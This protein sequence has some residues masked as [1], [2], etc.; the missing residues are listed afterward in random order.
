MTDPYPPREYW[1][2]VRGDYQRSGEHARH[3]LEGVAVM[4]AYSAVAIQSLAAV[5]FAAQYHVGAGLGMVLVS[6]FTVFVLFPSWA[7]RLDARRSA[8]ADRLPLYVRD[9]L[10]FH[11]AALLRA[12]GPRRER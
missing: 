5:L 11:T 4:A 8:I 1:Q 9:P 3:E 2:S 7:Q 10:A 12:Y 6:W